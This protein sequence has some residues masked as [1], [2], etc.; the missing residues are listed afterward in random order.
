MIELILYGGL[1]NQ[2][3]EY[4]FARS[5]QLESN[6]KLLL[7]NT[8]LFH[9]Y[10]FDDS[11][12]EFNL[13]QN[14]VFIKKPRRLIR[15]VSESRRFISDLGVYKLLSPLGIYIWRVNKYKNI[16]CKKQNNY[17]YGYF[18]TEKF[19]YKYSK[20]IKNELKLKSVYHNS[21]FYEKI[22]HSNSVCIHVRRGDYC[23][24]NMVICD[25]VYFKKAIEI[26]KAKLNDPTFF[27]FSDDM[28]W[29]KSN[30][31]IVEGINFVDEKAKDYEQLSLMSNCK[32]FIISNSTFSWWA[33][34][35]SENTDKLVIAPAM[36]MPYDKEK[37]D[38]YQKNWLLI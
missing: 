11:L 14:V 37:R 3:F 25:L 2:L 4:A 24:L 12:K 10:Q 6:D 18:Q 26:M 19:F 21:E 16:E 32:H 22:T 7:I 5:K 9:N 28:D 30:L 33:Q 38:I 13:P 29:A 27:L 35:L 34:Y 8:Y 1:G 17:I 20:E 31:N 15:I 36:W 23:K